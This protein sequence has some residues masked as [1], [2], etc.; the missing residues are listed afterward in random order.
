MEQILQLQR[1][2]NTARLSSLSLFV[3]RSLAYPR[4]LTLSLSLFLSVPRSLYLLRACLLFRLR[5]PL[6]LSLPFFFARYV[7][8]CTHT[9]ACG[10]AAALLL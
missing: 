1:K 7:S 8:S 6:P 4:A 10:A 3:E 2:F 9:L 5:W